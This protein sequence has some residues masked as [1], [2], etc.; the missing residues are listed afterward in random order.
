MV[1]AANPESDR[2]R[3]RPIGSSTVRSGP[4]D[5]LIASA[6]RDDGPRSRSGR[7]SPAHARCAAGKPATLLAAR[8]AGLRRAPP[9]R[10][11][12][13]GRGVLLQLAA[14]LALVDVERQ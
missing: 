1:P 11:L 7:R 14:H 3:P 13:V 4:S 8:T 5:E 10:V 9:R 6:D 12:P 2:V